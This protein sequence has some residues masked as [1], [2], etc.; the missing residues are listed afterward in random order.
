[1]GPS[2]WANLGRPRNRVASMD[3]RPLGSR[4]L[5]KTDEWPESWIGKAVDR[6]LGETIV[7]ALRPFLAA[8]ASSSLADTTLRRHFGNAWM[9]G[10]EIVRA[11][12]A[13]PTVFRLEGSE[14]LLRFVDDEGGPLL[15][16]RDT[17]AEQRSFDSTRRKLF[18]YLTAGRG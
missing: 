13:D 11:A 2:L 17:E 1:M 12:S 6:Q 9:L 4:L 3:P 15:L 7:S 10:G 18:K 14:L 8:L 5:A 16:H